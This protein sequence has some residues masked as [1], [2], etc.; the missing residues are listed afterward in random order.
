MAA[1]VSTDDLHVHLDGE[2]AVVVRQM[3]EE[4]DA[5]VGPAVV[6]RCVGEVA[7]AF[8]H[9]R[10]RSFIPLLVRRYARERLIRLSQPAQRRLRVVRD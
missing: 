7:G 2:L 3:H 10:V 1:R 5:A 6:D 8:A 9:A 4:F